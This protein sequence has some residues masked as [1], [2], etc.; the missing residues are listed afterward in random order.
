MTREELADYISKTYNIK[1]DNPFTGDFESAVFRHPDN[2]KWFAIVMK[3]RA[4]K[5]G[6]P[7]DNDID[8]VN[9]KVEPDMAEYIADGSSI[10]PA[11]HMNKKH[12][13]TLVLGNPVSDEK[14]KSLLDISY[15]LTENMKNKKG[16][17]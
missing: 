8:I 4:D 6:F 11:Y 9:V 2:R 16:K 5:L 3:V 1:F 12:W 10:F 7:D 17:K 14:I 15:N 13:V